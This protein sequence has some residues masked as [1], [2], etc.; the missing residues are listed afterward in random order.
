MST[1]TALE[2]FIRWVMRDV[3][4]LGQ[5]PAEVQSQH[6]DY[7]VDVLPDDASLRG[8]GLSGV[9]IRHGIPGVQVRVRAGSKCLLG[10]EGGDPSKPYVSLWDAT[11]VDEISFN[12]GTKGVARIGDLVT[13]YWPVMTATGALNGVP[14][15]LTL[16]AAAPSPGI[17]TT[18]STKVLAGD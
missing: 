4:W 7:T 11:S 10:F 8:R 12:N 18:A 5:Y 2:R 13:I 1:T 6:A 14:I 3:K 15:S 17:I 16:V 9:R